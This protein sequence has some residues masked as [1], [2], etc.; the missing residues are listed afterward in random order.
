MEYY[1]DQGWNRYGCFEGCTSLTSVNIPNSVT[2]LGYRSFGGCTSLTRVTIPN[3]VKELGSCCFE[4]CTNLKEVTCLA[5]EPP[6]TSYSFSYSFE[7]ERDKKLYVSESSLDA[8]KNSEYE[9]RYFGQI[10]P[11]SASDIKT[12]DMNDIGI[13]ADNGTLTLTNVPENEPINV[14]STT[15]QLLGTGTGN[16]SVNV[17][18]G[19][20]VI[21]RVGG[22]SY[23]LL[24][25]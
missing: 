22:K 10:L 6:Y 4:D 7:D 19:Q 24:A 23:K 14:Y 5:T 15:G 8:Y 13:T 25:K 2:K 9:W 12:V 1:N 3:S 18:G 11:L 17:Q 21:V 16:I 20:I